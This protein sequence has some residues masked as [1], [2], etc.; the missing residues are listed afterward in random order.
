M[1]RNV[2]LAVVMLV[3]PLAFGQDAATAQKESKK[4]HPGLMNPKLANEKAPEE[5]DVVFSTTK[6][7]F[8]ISVQRK[9]S[10]NGADRFYNMAKIG[11][12]QDI[13]IFR[14]IKGFMFQFGIHGDPKVNQKWFDATIKDDKNAG[15]SNKPGFITFA[16]TGQPNSR[17][18][19]FFVSLGDNNFLDRQG[20]TPFGQITKG[21]EVAQKINTEYGEN[22]R[23]ENVQGDYK[24]KGN[25]YIKK[26][27]P[28]IDFIK[29]VKIV[30]PKKK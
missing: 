18:T 29:S 13:G 15:I 21:M 14:A 4:P 20:F 19:Q 28:K 11:Y 27:F 25:A 17:S 26:R 9:W 5:F 8:V 2:M 1:T 30:T 16:K 24:S 10:P 6:G 23:N 7:D 12:F 22:P 3:A